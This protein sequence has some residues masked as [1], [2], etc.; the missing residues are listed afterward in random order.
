LKGK[1]TGNEQYIG[2]I[3]G[4]Q[5]FNPWSKAR[6]IQADVD[7]VKQ[8][9]GKALEGGVLRKEDEDKYKKILATLADTPE[10]AIYKIDALISSIQRNID[11]YKSLQQSAGRS[12][13]TRQP[14]PVKGETPI[15]DFRTK[16]GY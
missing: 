12:F 2:P 4:L 13:N 11:N 5:R 16:Y 14:L 9:V 6:Q 3:T 10:T 1:I 7:R 8:T 15:I